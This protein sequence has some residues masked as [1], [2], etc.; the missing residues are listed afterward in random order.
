MKNSEVEIT[1]FR[2]TVDPGYKGDDNLCTIMVPYGILLAW[3]KEFVLESFRGDDSSVSDE[4]LLE[5]WLDEYT[6]DATVGLYDYM[7]NNREEQLR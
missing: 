3:F 6:A 1:V 2:D 5:E 4:G 7:Q